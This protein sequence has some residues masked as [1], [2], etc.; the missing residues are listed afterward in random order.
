MLVFCG[1]STSNADDREENIYENV[2]NG[3]AGDM[4]AGWSSSEFEEY[5]N[6]DDDDDDD[7]GS[8]G[9]RSQTS[10][11]SSGVERVV[12]RTRDLF[13]RKI[14]AAAARISW[15]KP[16]ATDVQSMVSWSAQNY[17][18]GHKNMPYFFGRNFYT[19]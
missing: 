7:R 9:G 12:N 8:I 3:P 1:G 18:V 19:T 17:T 6:Y 5:D 2:G 15:G 16:G 10:Q 4:A 11:G 13:R 14:P